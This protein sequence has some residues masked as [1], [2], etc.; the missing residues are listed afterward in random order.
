MHSGTSLPMVKAAKSLAPRAL[1]RFAALRCYDNVRAIRLPDLLQ[2]LNP[3]GAWRLIDGH[4][5]RADVNVL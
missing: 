5:T 4:W 3:S 1:R 2:D